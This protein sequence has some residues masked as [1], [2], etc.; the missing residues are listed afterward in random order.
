MLQSPFFSVETRAFWIVASVALF[1]MMMAFG[2]AWITAV[3]LKDIAA[4]VGGT[5]SIPALARS[6]R[7]ALNSAPGGLPR[8]R[9][10][11]RAR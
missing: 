8:R 3:A 10:E 11:C 7:L 6:L 5:R 1:A 4:E 9:I 2:S